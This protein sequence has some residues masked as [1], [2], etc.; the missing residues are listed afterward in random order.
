VKH[1][2][3]FEL[4][5]AQLFAMAMYA[6]DEMILGPIESSPYWPEIQRLKQLAQDELREDAEGTSFQVQVKDII[7]GTSE[8][9]AAPPPKARWFGR[10]KDPG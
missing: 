3:E 9:P 1:Y 2:T 6:E 7:E 8:T 10:A 5:L 4:R